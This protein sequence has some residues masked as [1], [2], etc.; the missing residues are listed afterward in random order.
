MRHAAIVVRRGHGGK[1]E[2]L[3]E[4]LEVGLGADPDIAMGIDLGG[5]LQRD[6]HHQ[7]RE[8]VTALAAGDR[9]PPDPH[10]RVGF[11]QPQAADQRVAAADE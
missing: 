5:A 10:Q 3:V 7:P 4:R 8:P 11:D 2:A 9:D 1:P 6:F